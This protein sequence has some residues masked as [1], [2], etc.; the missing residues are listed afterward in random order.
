MGDIEEC[1][2][3]SERDYPVLPYKKKGKKN[4]LANLLRSVNICTLWLT[5]MRQGRC[6]G[7]SLICLQTRV[8]ALKVNKPP[9]L[10]P[11]L[12]L[13]DSPMVM[14]SENA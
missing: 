10:T 7:S 2:R 4:L 3:D 1:L 8:H 11:G 9:P 6:S 12:I 14:K 5:E 13:K